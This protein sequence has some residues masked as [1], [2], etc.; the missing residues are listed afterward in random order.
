MKTITFFLPHN[1]KCT[2]QLEG[3]TYKAKF[4]TSP[5]WFEQYELDS[6]TRDLIADYI[7]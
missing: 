4:S 3:L 2:V 7:L 5:N 1:V 6:E